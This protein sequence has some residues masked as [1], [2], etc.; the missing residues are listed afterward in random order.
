MRASVYAFVYVGAANG[1]DACKGVRQTETHNLWFGRTCRT[2]GGFGPDSG[3]G[4]SW[5]EPRKGN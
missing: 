4:E 5:F 3:S 2:L 1:G